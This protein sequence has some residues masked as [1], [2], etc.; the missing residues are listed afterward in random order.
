MN[1][2]YFLVTASGRWFRPRFGG[3][4]QEPEPKSRS[5]AGGVRVARALRGVL[6]HRPRSVNSVIRQAE[7]RRWAGILGATLFFVAIANFLAFCIV[8]LIIGGEAVS[9]KVE[10]GRY[11]VRHRGRY[12]E[13]SQGVWTY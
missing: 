9:G 13:V 7:M 10:D 11:Y 5:S 3:R 6:S 8:S 1:C 2:L 12:T 4:N